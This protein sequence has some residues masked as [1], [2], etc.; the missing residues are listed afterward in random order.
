MSQFATRGL[1]LFTSAKEV[2]FTTNLLVSVQLID[3]VD[4]LTVAVVVVCLSA[5]GKFDQFLCVCAYM[6]FCLQT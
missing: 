3:L 5:V 4:H 2:V 6:S 1:G